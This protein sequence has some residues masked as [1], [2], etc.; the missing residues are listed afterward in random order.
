MDRKRGFWE[1]QE[2]SRAVIVLVVLLVI[3]ASWGLRGWQNYRDER[4][5][6]NQMMGLEY[7]PVPVDEPVGNMGRN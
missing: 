3:V 5:E 6:N 1:G 4:H 2:R 7:F